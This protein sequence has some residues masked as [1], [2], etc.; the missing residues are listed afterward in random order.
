[1]EKEQEKAQNI[2]GW[3]MAGLIPLG[4]LSWIF[5]SLTGLFTLAFAA[6]VVFLF[7]EQK[8]LRERAERKV[9]ELKRQLEGK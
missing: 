6:V 8:K 1:M 4:V 2:M 7:W 3:V 9:A 5:P